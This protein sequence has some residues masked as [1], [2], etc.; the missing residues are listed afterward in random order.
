MPRIDPLPSAP[1]STAA[2]PKPKKLL[3]PMAERMRMQH[4]SL[5]TERSYIAWA[6]RIVEPAYNGAWS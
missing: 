5:K 6:A 2:A 3:G 1:H 4:L